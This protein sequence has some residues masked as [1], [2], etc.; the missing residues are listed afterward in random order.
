MNRR[1]RRAAP[2]DPRAV[3][4]AHSYGCPDCDSRTRLQVDSLGVHHLTVLHDDT[5]PWLTQKEETHDGCN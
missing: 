1:Q 2:L 3:R 4:Y 5:C